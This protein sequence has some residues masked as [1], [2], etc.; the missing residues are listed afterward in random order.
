[1][2]IPGAIARLTAFLADL[3]ETARPKINQEINQLVAAVNADRVAMNELQGENTA[4]DERMD[5]FDAQPAGMRR[6]LRIVQSPTSPQTDFQVIME[7]F[8]LSDGLTVLENVDVLI[9]I[10][11][12]GAGGLDTGTITAD[13]FYYVHIC[14][15]PSDTMIPATV[16]VVSLSPTPALPTGYT[17]YGLVDP[18]PPIL[19][20]SA[21]EL[22]AFSHIPGSGTVMYY[23]G[24]DAGKADGVSLTT[25]DTW[26]DGDL[27]TIVPPGVS[28]AWIGFRADWST[29]DP[30]TY[31]VY[32]RPNW[33]SL[34]ADAETYQRTLFR[35][36]I[37]N[38]YRGPYWIPLDEDG[39]FKYRPGDDGTHAPTLVAW[40]A[41]LQ[42][43]T[44]EV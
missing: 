8:T 37:A 25:G 21:G 39:V 27:S 5:D 20:D 26:H 43:G 15:D 4:L 44:V 31:R 42:L 22:V 28:G 14:H 3:W 24:E 7:R 18:V 17:L 23:S 33:G 38:D 6:G 35:A 34:G 9:D 19:T 41:G 2:A 13:S 11:D 10:G 29:S 30:G 12:S 32:M 36:S 16:G 1:M 40:L